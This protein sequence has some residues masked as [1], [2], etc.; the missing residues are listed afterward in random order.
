MSRLCL[1]RLC[2]VG[3]YNSPFSLLSWRTFQLKNCELLLFTKWIH[4]LK[5]L[6]FCKFAWC[7]FIMKVMRVHYFEL[8]FYIYFFFEFN[9]RE[10]HSR[11]DL[12][13]KGPGTRFLMSKW[14]LHV[15]T[16]VY[17]SLVWECTSRLVIL[18]NWFSCTQMWH[19]GY[20]LVFNYYYIHISFVLTFTSKNQSDVS[21]LFLHESKNLLCSQ[22]LSFH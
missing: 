12:A 14:V 11:R 19:L 20:L 18:P 16:T 9:H 13:R 4:C 10:L 6:P 5:R 17:R 1:S 3:F 15:L 22:I 2:S 21:V 7:W 8:W